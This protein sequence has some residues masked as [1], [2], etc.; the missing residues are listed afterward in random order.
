MWSMTP[1]YL[2]AMVNVDLFNAENIYQTISS[3]LRP[4]GTEYVKR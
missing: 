2:Q 4:T 3:V 1:V